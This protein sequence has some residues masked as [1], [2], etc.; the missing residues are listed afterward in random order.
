LPEGNHKLK[1][2]VTGKKNYASEGIMVSLGKV[3]TYTGE[4][5]R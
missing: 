1:V 4:I 3:V 5:A 2:V